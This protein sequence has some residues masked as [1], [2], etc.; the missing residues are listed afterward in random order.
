[1]GDRLEIRP[2]TLRTAAGGA[3]G[4]AERLTG[5]VADL[6]AALEAAGGCWGD[7]EPG[8]AF[9]DGYRPARD[10]VLARLDGLAE[11]A[12][13]IGPGLVSMADDFDGAEEASTIAGGGS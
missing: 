11:G 10:A 12:A 9:G 8:R 6:R 13:S 5:A 2:A 1:M 3:D 7:D 4:T